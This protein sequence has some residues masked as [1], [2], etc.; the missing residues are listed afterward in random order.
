MSS[1]WL[2]DRLLG[3]PLL[4]WKLG[5]ELG[6]DFGLATFTELR[7]R[8][9]DFWSEAE[10]FA[11][12]LAVGS[13]LDVALVTLIATPATLGRSP[14]VRQGL[15]GALQ[16]LPA[17]ALGFAPAGVRYSKAQRALSVLLK[18][19]QYGAVGMACGLTG[20]A[21]ANTAALTRRALRPKAEN[22]SKPEDEYEELMPSIPRTALLWASFMAGSA[23]VR[24]QLLAG[25]DT[26]VG[27]LPVSKRYVALPAL[28]TAAVR[29]ANNI[30][31]GEH[32]AQQARWALVQ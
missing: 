9:G 26:A 28:V 12:D 22:K 24:Y 2:R 21:M 14:A 20:Q 7:R 5:C 30:V 13:V 25:L 17:A 11:A 32:F 4:V 10:F 15:L 19:A 29:F 27:A 1:A 16:R 6:L 23:N 18:G 3:D 31:G 8:G